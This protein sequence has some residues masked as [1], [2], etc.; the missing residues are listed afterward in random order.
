M[1]D[2]ALGYKFWGSVLRE[3][4]E[5]VLDN[6][7]PLPIHVASPLGSLLDTGPG[8]ML[9]LC[10]LGLP[11]TERHGLTGRHSDDLCQGC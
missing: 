6:G 2:L 5:H 3:A 7:E 4:V 11:E 8:A 10:F 1:S 9:S